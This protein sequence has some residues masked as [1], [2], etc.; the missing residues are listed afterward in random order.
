MWARLGST[1]FSRAPRSPFSRSLQT[2][3]TTPIPIST[4]PPSPPFKHTATVPYHKHYI[5]LHTSSPPSEWP[6]HPATSLHSA[7]SQKVKP[8][9]AIVNFSYEPS[10]DI[11]GQ[12]GASRV[13][14]GNTSEAY[15]ATFYHHASPPYTLPSLSIA[16]IPEIVKQLENLS[17]VAVN[18]QPVET[19]ADIH[20][21][22][23][24][25]G[26]RDCKCGDTGGAVHRTILSHLSNLNPSEFPKIHLHEIAHVGGHKYA[27]NVLVFPAGDWYGDLTPE[28]VPTFLS[29]LSTSRGIPLSAREGND[30]LLWKKWRGRMGMTQDEQVAHYNTRSRPLVESNDKTESSPVVQLTFETHDGV[31]MNVAA[32]VGKSLMVVAKEAGLPSIEGACDGQLEVCLISSMFSKAWRIY[33]LIWRYSARHATSTSPLHPHM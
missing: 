2:R 27:A 4:P 11:Q 17:E 19:N 22:V 32:E 5:I 26:S 14:F 1:W 21:Y 7:L 18:P 6:S 20:L 29:A 15:P 33:I 25:H 10:L 3:T 23:C 13:E 31:K 28:D 16:T 30:A 9:G 8:L 24:T 12:A